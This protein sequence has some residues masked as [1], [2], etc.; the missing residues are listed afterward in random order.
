ME[1]IENS[2]SDWVLYKDNQII[3]FNKPAGMLTQSGEEGEKCLIDFAQ[4]YCK[5]IVYPLHRLDRPVAGL[6]I[7]AK[8]KKALHF[9][10][11]QLEERA[12]KKK[13]LA[14]VNPPPEKDN[15]TLKHYLKRSGNLKKAFVETSPK[16]GFK[17][18]ILNYKTIFQASNYTLLEI[19]LITGR[20][21]QIRAQLGKI[22]SPIKGDVKYGARRSNPD[23][24]IDLLAR[25]ITFKHPTNLEMMTLTAPIPDQPLWK[26]AGL[27]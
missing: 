15:G 20:F 11:M 18:A 16:A 6:V 25:E 27:E 17:E 21:H 10:N 7:F 12:I 9:L 26:A 5:H 3:V 4:I 22:G 1:T 14:W 8:N 23:R 2:I 13:Y 19:E 24:T